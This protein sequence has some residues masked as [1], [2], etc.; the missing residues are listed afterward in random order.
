MKVQ[1]GKDLASHSGPESCGGAREGAA[2]ALTGETGG[3]AI[4]PRNQ[5]IGTPTQLSDAE[6]N[7]GQGDQCE[8]WDGPARSKTLHTPG[9][10]LHRSWEISAAPGGTTPGNSGKAKRRKPEPQTVEKSDAL[11]V[12]GKPSN[13]GVEPAEM[14]E[15]RSAAKGNAEQVPASRTQSRSSC[16]S[17]GLERVRQAARRNRRLQFTALLHHITPQ[18][19]VDSFYSLQRNAAAGVDG[20]TWREYEKILPQRVTELHRLLHAG[21]YRATPSRRVYI[22][23]ADGRQRPLGIASLEDKIVQQAVVTVLSAIYEEDF[24]GFSYGFRPRRGQHNAL[25]ALT[26]GIKSRKVNWIVDA[27][28]RSF[29]DEIDH[30]WML[31]FVEHRIADQ[32]IIRLIR[33]WLE[34][35][36]IEDGKRIPAMKGTPQGAVIS[37][38][39]AN[40]YL[41]YAFD[42]WVQ[43]WRKQ[44]GRGEVIVIRYADDSVAGFENV[45][46]AQAFL[47]ELR[48]RLAKFGLALHPDKTRLIEF[49][50]FAV[51]RRRRRGQGRPETFDFLGFTHCC[52][53]D[54]A[55]K[56]QVVRLTAKKRMRATLTAIR[57]KL[58]QRRHEPVPTVG[59]WLQRVLNGYFAYHAVPTNLLRL[60]GFRKE[61]CRAWRHALLRRSQRSRLNWSRFNRLARK[62]VPPCRVLHPYPDQR[63]LA[64]RP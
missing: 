47:E 58:Y 34:A 12:P 17:T 39:L 30:G 43:H 28:I 55:G 15:G 31:Q 40:I 45:R 56:F 44:P 64:S 3:S 54:R 61:V 27:D 21:A 57:A 6:G 33:K 46:T 8:S 26:V 36:V 29:F 5:E 32:R 35:G 20:V 60:D 1:Y 37:P 14:V 4:E 59:S 23:K 63:F 53:T 51:D 41:H 49:G 42:L 25:D 48:E 10:F 16:A 2:E 19:L 7:T 11:I 13:K 62:Y 22:P 9:S 50:R 18:L 52:G 38:L 24:L